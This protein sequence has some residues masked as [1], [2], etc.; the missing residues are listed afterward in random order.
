MPINANRRSISCRFCSNAVSHHRSASIIRIHPYRILPSLPNLFWNELNEI[1]GK[2]GQI[3]LP[4]SCDNEKS[5][6]TGGSTH[7][8][9]MIDGYLR[10]EILNLGVVVVIVL[11][12]L[13]WKKSGIVAQVKTKGEWAINDN[14]G[15]LKGIPPFKF[16]QIAQWMRQRF[17]L[18]DV[19][20]EPSNESDENW[21]QLLN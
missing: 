15:D 14:I 2:N 4:K 16:L 8:V 5:R 6:S 3:S 17:Q 18:V 20:I 13:F 21:N 7:Y 9:K 1:S 11:P 10:E 12:K 19:E